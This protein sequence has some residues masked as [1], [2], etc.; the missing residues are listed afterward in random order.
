MKFV[1]GQ[2][3]RVVKQ[4]LRYKGHKYIGKCGVIRHAS[5]FGYH[6]IMDDTGSEATFFEEELEAV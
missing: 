2:K 4:G 1:P 6:V 5:G 3:V